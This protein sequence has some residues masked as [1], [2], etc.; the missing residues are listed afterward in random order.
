MDPNDLRMRFFASMKG[1]TPEMAARLS[2]IDYARE[3]ALVA[4]SADTNQGIGVVRIAADPDNAKAE[5]AVTV[6]SDWK[7]K[8]LG[9]L[10]MTRIID[11]ARARGIG[12]LEGS[13]LRENTAMLEM[14]ATLGCSFSDTP[15]DP[16]IVLAT[17]KI[18]L[19]S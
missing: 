9:H 18:G 19:R 4:L 13:I 16:K 1:L 3:L 14:C 10:M 17:R 5:F 12:V 7:G 15:D 8:G 2:Q 11:I 6:R